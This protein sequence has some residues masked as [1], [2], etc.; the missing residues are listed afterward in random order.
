M[1]LTLFELETC[2]SV[3]LSPLKHALLWAFRTLL[4]SPSLTVHLCKRPLCYMATSMYQSAQIS[5]TK[6]LLSL[7][8]CIQPHGF[9]HHL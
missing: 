3:G 7:M 9:K 4:S 5:I 6:C 8:N 1:V 2:D